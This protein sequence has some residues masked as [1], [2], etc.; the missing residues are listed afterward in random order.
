MI[1]DIIPSY[2]NVMISRHC[3]LPAYIQLV[4]FCPHLLHC[5]DSGLIPILPTYQG[6]SYLSGPLPLLFLLS[7]MLSPGTY[8]AHF[9][10]SFRSLHKCHLREIFPDHPIYNCNLS[11][12]SCPPFLLNFFHSNYFT[13]SLLSI[14]P[15]LEYQQFHESRNF[16]SS[17]L[18]NPLYLNQYQE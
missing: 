14:S 7:R 10:S 13:L 16:I 11:P 18:L 9:L 4:T 12:T 5:S 15:F 8:M 17:Q 3:G 2:K 1:F 6:N